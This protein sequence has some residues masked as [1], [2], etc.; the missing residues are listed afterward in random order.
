GARVTELTVD[1][2]PVD[3]AAE[4]TVVVNEFLSSPE[5]N[6]SPFAERGTRREAGLTDISALTRY[7]TD[8]GPLT[9]PKPGRV[10][11]IR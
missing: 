5:W 10:R 8:E 9:S 3:P 6:G 4:Y 11:V 7:V 1:D 2:E